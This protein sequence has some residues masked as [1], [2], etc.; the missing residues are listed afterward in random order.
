MSASDE[1]WIQQTV[2]SALEAADNVIKANF[3][4]LFGNTGTD[5]VNLTPGAKDLED[6][7]AMYHEALVQRLRYGIWI[8]TP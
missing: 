3:P 2:T 8:S 5:P 6:L 7:R 4:E 1:L